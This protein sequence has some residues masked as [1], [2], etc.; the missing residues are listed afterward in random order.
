[1]TEF[2]PIEFML[3]QHDLA[4]R[5]RYRITHWAVNDGALMELASR[6][7]RSTFCDEKMLGKP[8]LEREYLGIPLRFMEQWH[9]HYEPRMGVQYETYGSSILIHDYD[10][11]IWHGNDQKRFLKRIKDSLDIARA[12]NDRI[13]PKDTIVAR[14]TA[15]SSHG[16]A[17]NTVDP[18]KSDV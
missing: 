4:N 18:Q 2:N 7:W 15:I 8:M 13:T 14:A 16:V 9:P 12:L 6:D 5:N 1:M 17:Q 11:S 10:G 3:E